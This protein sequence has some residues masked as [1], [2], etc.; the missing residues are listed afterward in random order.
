MQFNHS[1]ILSLPPKHVD[2]QIHHYT[3][4]DLFQTK[5]TITAV[6]IALREREHEFDV[7][8]CTFIP[9]I[10]LN[11]LKQFDE[12]HESDDGDEADAFLP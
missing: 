5:Q 12:K 11:I 9:P 8:Q 7:L 4:K 6:T 1:T 2:S 3:I 10:Q